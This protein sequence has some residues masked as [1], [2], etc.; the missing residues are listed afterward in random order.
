MIAATENQAAA[1]AVN[2]AMTDHPAE[3]ENSAV[4]DHLATET[5]TRAADRPCTKPLAVTAVQDAS[6]RSVHPAI[7]RY[8]AVSV[9]TS[10]AVV[11]AVL[12]QADLAMTDAKDRALKAEKTEKCMMPLVENAA[13]IA[14]FLSGHLPANRYS[15]V[16][17]LKKVATVAARTTANS[18]T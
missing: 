14:K 1:L 15:A 10:K 16:I 5:D 9:L 12:D 6:Y 11:E 3:I 4:A 18:W 8:S 2:L 13:M 7:D 17:V